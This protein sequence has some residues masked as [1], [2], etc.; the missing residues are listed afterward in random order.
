M[1]W[2]PNFTVQAREFSAESLKECISQFSLL[3]NGPALQRTPS[4]LLQCPC[5]RPSAGARPRLLAPALEKAAVC[6]HLQCA[7]CT[8]SAV[9]WSRGRGIPCWQCTEALASPS[10]CCVSA[11]W[12]GCRP[13]NRRGEP[14]RC[15][16][17]PV[18]APWWS[19]VGPSL[20]SR[21]CRPRSWF[22][23]VSPQS[24]T[25]EGGFRLAAIG[26]EG[27]TGLLLLVV[28]EG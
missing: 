18:P 17:V 2:V 3:A 6:S 27:L 8:C 1:A 14:R 15:R 12:S 22:C 24:S 10:C 11:P 13:L 16:G 20:P 19:S 7:C 28:G 5:P 25:W 23:T 21:A 26:R 9:I 4:R